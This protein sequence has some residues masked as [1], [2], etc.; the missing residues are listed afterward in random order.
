MLLE[1]VKGCCKS[2]AVKLTVNV[3]KNLI[4]LV[5]LSQEGSLDEGVPEI[6]SQEQTLNYSCYDAYSMKSVGQVPIDVP[7]STP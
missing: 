7:Y 2:K 4:I 3:Y 5:N 6:T 1:E